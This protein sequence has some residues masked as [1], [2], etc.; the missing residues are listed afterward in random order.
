VG[1][2]GAAMSHGSCGRRP[3]SGVAGVCAALALTFGARAGSA[4]PAT[5]APQATTELPKTQTSGL[6]LSAG[7]GTQ[8]VMFGVQ[9]AFYLQLPRSLFRVAPYASIGTLCFED[10]CIGGTIFGALGSWGNKHR[11]TIDAFYGTVTATSISIH[12]ETAVTKGYSGPGLAVGY[13]YMA[14]SGFFVRGDI[15]GAYAL[16]PPILAPEHRLYWTLTIVG[17]GFKFW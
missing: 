9:A 5:S 13:E 6:G 7:L 12:G 16:G 2:P 11:L 3:K 15:G 17:L 4:A 10:D 8:Y 14:F 1:E